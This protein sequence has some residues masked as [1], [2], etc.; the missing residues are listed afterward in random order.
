MDV[1][2]RCRPGN[3]RTPRTRALGNALREARLDRDLGLRQFAKDIGR[4]PSLLSRWETGDR[5]PTPTDVAQILGKLGVTGD[6]YDEIIELAYGTDD[7]RWLAT[8]LPEQK[9]QLAALLDFERSASAITDISPLVMPGMI[10][11]SEY[12]N[13]IMSDG[14]VPE[15]DIS[16]RV[17]IR[18]G[19]RHVL[20][21]RDAVDYVAL[22]GEGALRQMIG[23]PEIMVDQLGFLLEVA[24]W[25]S[26]SVRVVPFDSGWHPALEGPAILIESATQ[27]AMVYVELRDSG[28]FLHAGSAVTSYRKAANTVAGRAMS[29]E[30]SLAVIALVKS[31]WESA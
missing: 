25:P 22:I 2:Q 17:N 29:A 5:T 15:G 3:N 1:N 26:V 14:G 12:T 19:R 28:L 4:D 30:D 24:Q 10:Q 13:A 18:M 11:T 31:G 20:T 23:S 27:P 6:Q 8:S 16:T 21:R 9:A 7:P